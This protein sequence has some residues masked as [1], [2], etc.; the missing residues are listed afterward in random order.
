MGGRASGARGVRWVGSGFLG[1]G[2]AE[3][4]GTAADRADAAAG[5]ARSPWKR[6]RVGREAISLSVFQQ[7][8]LNGN[9]LV[10]SISHVFT[11]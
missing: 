1:V 2:S 8:P 5:E 9:L 11:G 6:E 10:E 4:D 3:D 7:P